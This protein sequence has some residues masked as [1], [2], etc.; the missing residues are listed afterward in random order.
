MKKKLVTDRMIRNGI[1]GI[2]NNTNKQSKPGD[3]DKRIP[4]V[5]FQHL[6]TSGCAPCCHEVDDEDIDDYDSD[7]DDEE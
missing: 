7:D 6:Y 5:Q 2:Q 1:H 3:T 4:V